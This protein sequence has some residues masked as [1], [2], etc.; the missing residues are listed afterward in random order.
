MIVATAGH[1]DHG[2]T[3]LVKALTGVDTDRLPEEK[4]RGLTIELGFAYLPITGHD[5]IGFIDV[6]GHE[7]FIRNALCGLAGTD[8]VLL[9][10]AADDGPMP[11]TIEHLA[12]IDLLGIT[13]GAVV[14]TKVDRVTPARV[15]QV[16]EE[17]GVLLA[18]TTLQGVAVFPVSAPSGEG[19]P[20]L[21]GHLAEQG[22]RMPPRSTAG[23]FRLAVD[24]TFDIVGTGFVVTGTVFSGSVGVGDVVEVPDIGARLR[25]RGIH[26][27]D[28][29]AETGRA[30][31]RCA[32]NLSGPEL[33]KETITRGQWLCAEGAPAPV[34]KLDVELRVLPGRDEALAH[35]TPVHIH[36]GAAE[37]TGRVAVLEGS[38]IAAGA[39]GLAQLVL[40]K[41]IGAVFGDHLIVRDQSA[42]F[43][44]GGGRVIDIFP[45]RRG[46]ARP[47]RLAQLRSGGDASAEKAL[48]ALLELSP[49]GVDLCRFAANRNLT[50]SELARVEQALAVK[51]VEGEGDRRGTAGRPGEAIRFAF[52]P[53]SWDGVRAAVLER[54]DAWHKDN[55]G[56]QGIGD[57]RIL[58]GS[59]LAMAPQVQAAV[60]AELVREGVLVRTDLGLRLPTHQASLAPADARLWDRLDAQFVDAQARPLTSR[61]LAVT[62]G[63]DLRRIEALLTQASRLGLVHYVSKF[64][65]AR[66]EDL[67]GLARIAERIAAAGNG[68]ISVAELRDASGIGRNMCVEVL[69]FFDKQRFTRRVGDRH[70][71]VKPAESLFRRAAP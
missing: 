30:G 1:V 56:A 67:L 66:T 45:P 5:T 4:R 31:Q 38:S 24:R 23:R 62:T 68:S 10:V 11:Q 55:P 70:S 16:R 14:V 61:D 18:G 58:S 36:L 64:R 69:E 40:D 37:T 71:V 15:A 12:I 32:I 46:R 57:R 60:A 3:L 42:R 7:R 29:R 59:G 28:A 13:H 50:A 34:T 21:L 48:S 20:A 54:L 25:V 6:P 33:R 8:F 49:E 52:A 27:Q 47:Q 35:W 53:R 2:K 41:P 43:T 22:A 19:V 17:I 63:L 9:I 65:V 51:I 26:A 39:T 44:L